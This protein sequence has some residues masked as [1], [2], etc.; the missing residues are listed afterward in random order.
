[1][2]QFTCSISTCEAAAQKGTIREITEQ[3][4][5]MGV[6]AAQ[7]SDGQGRAF[8]FLSSP[9]VLVLGIENFILY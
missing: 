4:A 7:G 9:T 3:A 5:L 1:M 8:F 6:I 2:S